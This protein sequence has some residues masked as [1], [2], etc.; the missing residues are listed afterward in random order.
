MTTKPKAV[1]ATETPQAAQVKET[2]QQAEA[3]TAIPAA[4]D[5]P[6]L[7]LAKAP[8]QKQP[9]ASMPRDAHTGIG[10]VYKRLSDG[11]RVRTDSPQQE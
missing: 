9:T 8:P 7:A 5:A 2:S 3:A 10:G 6:A 11:S 4:G 1:N